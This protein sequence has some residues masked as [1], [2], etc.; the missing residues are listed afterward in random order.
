[1]LEVFLTAEM[2]AAAL[3]D[4]M[5]AYVAGLTRQDN[6]YPETAEAH[7]YWDRGWL[8]GAEISNAA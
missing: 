6:P 1:M 5:E 3:D 8:I 4:G 2:R 7:T